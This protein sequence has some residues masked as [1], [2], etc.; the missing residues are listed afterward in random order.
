MTERRKHA[1]KVIALGFAL[2]VLILPSSVLAQDSSATLD[3]VVTQSVSGNPASQAPFTFLLAG[4]DN[5]PMPATSQVT[6]KGSGQAYFG[7]ISYDRIGI[8]RYTVKRVNNNLTDYSD[9]STVYTVQVTV[10]YRL[11]NPTQLM[12]TA[13]ATK[14]GSDAKEDLIFHSTYRGRKTPPPPQANQVLPN[15]GSVCPFCLIALGM[16]LIVSSGL[17]VRKSGTKDQ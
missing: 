2:L 7:A 10:T 9:D 6:I 13:I 16:V 17:S 1:K 8:Y 4:Q 11:D 3:F 14:S 15:L 12:A 5:A